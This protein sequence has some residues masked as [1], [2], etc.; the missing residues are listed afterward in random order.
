M[1]KPILIILFFLLLS[2]LHAQTGCGIN[3]F[4]ALTIISKK[5]SLTDLDLDISVQLLKK[6][7]RDKCYDYIGKKN[8]HEYVIASRTY[9]FGQI[10]LKRNS[11]SAAREY[12]NY[13]KREH[14]SAEEQ[15]SFSFEKIFA[16]RPEDV[17]SLLRNDHDLLNQLGWGFINNHSAELT[18]KNCKAVFFKVSPKIREIYPKYKKE[19]DYLLN[20][21][22]NEL[23]G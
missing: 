20:D 21:I 8:G 14:G 22:A 4:K 16:K 18:E 10:C 13:L 19:I 15:L 12:I 11:H 9:L 3:Q 1:R 23:K 7:E 17:L 2:S 5:Y 6:L